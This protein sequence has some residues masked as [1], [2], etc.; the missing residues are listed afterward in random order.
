MKL[1][2]PSPSKLGGEA[3]PRVDGRAGTLCMPTMQL[4]LFKLLRGASL[5]VSVAARRFMLRMRPWKL[6]VRLSAWVRRQRR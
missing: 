5:C 6:L 4:L 3:L 2:Q 1:V